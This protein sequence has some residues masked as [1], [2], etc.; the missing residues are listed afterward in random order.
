MKTNTNKRLA[1]FEQV[2]TP[3]LKE[4]GNGEK[5]ET[6]KKG[7]YFTF[8][9]NIDEFLKYEAGTLKDDYK[10]ERNMTN[11]ELD[12]LFGLPYTSS[13]E[14]AAIWNTNT[15]ARAKYGALLYFRGVALSTDY[16]TVLIFDQPQKNAVEKTFYFYEYEFY[17][18]QREEKQRGRAKMWGEF[19]KDANKLSLKAFEIVKK[20]N[21]KQY[22]EKTKTII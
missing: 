1:E 9:H 14:F 17:N 6:L 11:N 5:W 3:L 16:K 8:K 2:K 10:S 7:V 18:Y 4:W 22:G 21:G 20:Y 15:Q 19:I 12:N 13:G